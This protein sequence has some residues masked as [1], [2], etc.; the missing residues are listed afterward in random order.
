M[1]YLLPMQYLHRPTGVHKTFTLN[2]RWSQECV[3]FGEHI[4]T[5][6]LS[7][8]INGW[9][10]KISEIFRQQSN[11]LKAICWLVWNDQ[12]REAEDICQSV[13]LPCCLA[14]MR[15]ILSLTH[16]LTCLEEHFIWQSTRSYTCLQNSLGEEACP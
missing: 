16:M 15:R 11:H 13:S 8:D 12:N 5:C 10:L 4:L 7:F 14:L 9:T 6:W 2:N 1:P 3:P